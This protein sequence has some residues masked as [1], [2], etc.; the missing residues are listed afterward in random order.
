MDLDEL[1][2]EH[3]LE[4]QLALK[5]LKEKQFSLQEEMSFE[6]DRLAEALSEFETRKFNWHKEI[7][8]DYSDDY[9]YD[10]RDLEIY[11]TYYDKEMYE[12]ERPVFLIQD[13]VD[14][15]EKELL[16]LEYDIEEV[17]Y[18]FE[19]EWENIKEEY[20]ESAVMRWLA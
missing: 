9:D 18:K 17:E 5:S 11:G 3:D 20:L 2:K 7:R 19:C 4:K 10:P 15:Y 14:R 1:K 16:K 12:M 6:E 13:R 8:D